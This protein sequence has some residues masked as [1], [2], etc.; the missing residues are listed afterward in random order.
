MERWYVRLEA[1]R[2]R[3][4]SPETAAAAIAI[5]LSDVPPQ[6]RERARQA[7]LDKIQVLYSELGL[8]IPKWLGG[9]GTM[10]VREMS[11]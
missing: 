7:A 5:L 1:D 3:P 8:P 11:K 10:E 9:V 2:G 4:V 6:H